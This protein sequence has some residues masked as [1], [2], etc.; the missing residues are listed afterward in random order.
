MNWHEGVNICHILEQFFLV[1]SLSYG[2]L[3]NIQFL[4]WQINCPLLYQMMLPQ[5]TQAIQFVYSLIIHNMKP[6]C[7]LDAQSVYYMIKACNAT[8]QQDGFI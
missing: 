7:D 2:C 6:T 3:S 4:D 8:S 1:C 5:G